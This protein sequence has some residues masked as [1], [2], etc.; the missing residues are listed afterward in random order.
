MGLWLK[1]KRSCKVLHT[2]QSVHGTDMGSTQETSLRFWW[3]V[4]KRSE[5]EKGRWREVPV[6]VLDMKC[7][8]SERWQEELE[9]DQTPIPIFRTWGQ[10]MATGTKPKYIELH[11]QTKRLKWETSKLNIHH[12]LNVSMLSEIRLEACYIMKAISSSVLV[13]LSI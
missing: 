2:R 8:C 6:F 1:E 12:A 10:K 11:S 5:N 7:P 4:A 13:L 9:L 3:L